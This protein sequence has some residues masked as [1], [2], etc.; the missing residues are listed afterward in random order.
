MRF[1]P[2]QVFNWSREEQM[3]YRKCIV[4]Q[5]WGSFGVPV[6]YGNYEFYCGEHYFEKNKK[7]IQ[8]ESIQK[9]QPRLF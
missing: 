5:K 7:T 8:K 2:Y 9:G 3:K 4:C 1:S 6:Q